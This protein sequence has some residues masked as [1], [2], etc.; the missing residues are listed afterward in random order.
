M[1]KLKK[2]NSDKLGRVLGMTVVM[3]YI[4]NVWSS[5]CMIAGEKE[6]GRVLLPTS[7]TCHLWSL[8]FFLLR[9]LEC[10]FPLCQFPLCQLPFGQS[11]SHQK[12]LQHWCVC[13]HMHTSFPLFPFLSLPLPVCFT[14]PP[15]CSSLVSSLP[16]FYIPQGKAW[17]HQLHSDQLHP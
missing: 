13:M 10:L 3:F 17:C 5:G 7:A 4:S 6:R 1:D 12:F 9:I 11:M 8:W 16:F 2:T 15:S 14:P